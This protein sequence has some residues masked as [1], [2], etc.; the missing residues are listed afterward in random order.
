MPTDMFD[1][2]RK[3]LEEEF[4]NKQSA[5]LTQKLKAVFEKKATRESLKEAAGITD[6]AVL[7][8]LMALNVTHQSM[9][10][11]G[12]F[13]LVE[14]AWAD[15]K[16]DDRERAALLTAARDKGIAPGTP[17]QQVLDE[18]LRHPPGPDG[19]AAWYAYA[20]ELGRKLTPAE[21]HTVRDELVRRGRA[22]ATASGGLLGLGNRVSDKEEAVLAAIAAAFPD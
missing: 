22:V 3:S 5:T 19:R 2:R 17:A 4:F 10:A 15:G 21:R 20:A 7:D 13:P 9:T 1:A 6:E 14:V 11:F 12:L 8:A 16:L 18:W